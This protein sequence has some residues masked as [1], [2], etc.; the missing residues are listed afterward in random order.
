MKFF[1]YLDNEFTRITFEL[2]ETFDIKKQAES[3]VLQNLVEVVRKWLRFL[4]YFK[5]IFKYLKCKLLRKF[6]EKV[7][8]QALLQ[9]PK[10]EAKDVAPKQE[11]PTTEVPVV[12]KA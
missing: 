1:E 9:K 12:S 5:V 8:L 4:A 11:L 6:P 10:G 2:R 3:K 7:D